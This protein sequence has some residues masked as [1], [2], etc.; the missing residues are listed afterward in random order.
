LDHVVLSTESSI[1][2]YSIDVIGVWYET[3]IV[4]V[5]ILANSDV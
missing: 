3:G 1:L 2:I 4:G 5:A